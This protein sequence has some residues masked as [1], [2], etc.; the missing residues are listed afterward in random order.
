M[1]EERE[2]EIDRRKKRGLVDTG[3]ELN[4]SFIEFWRPRMHN[5]E[6]YYVALS[7]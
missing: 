3:P 2:K 4:R 7:A 1:M 6:D 5:L